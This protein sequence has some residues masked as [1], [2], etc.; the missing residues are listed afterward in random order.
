MAESVPALACDL[1]GATRV[2]GSAAP[3]PAD[4]GAYRRRHPRH[5]VDWIATLQS[6][7]RDI[8]VRVVDISMGGAGLEVV[9]ELQIGE[10]ATLFFE[11][12]PGRPAMPVVVKSLRGA[13]RR[14]GVALIPTEALP[15]PLVAAAAAQTGAQAARGAAPSS[16]TPQ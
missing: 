13:V 3:L 4:L 10:S 7:G 5:E 8:A 6:S 1:A 9:S 15:G 14:A 16:G 11:Q 2:A 12:L